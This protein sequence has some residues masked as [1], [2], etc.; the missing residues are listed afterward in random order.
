MNIKLNHAV[1]L[2]IGTICSFSLQA[3]QEGCL[4]EHHAK[5]VQAAVKILENSRLPIQQRSHLKNHTKENIFYPLHAD[6][7]LLPIVLLLG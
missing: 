7:Y 6:Y 4:P 5:Q 1:V 2:T 3:S